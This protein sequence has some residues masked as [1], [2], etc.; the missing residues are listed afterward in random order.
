MSDV[1]IGRRAFV[2]GS[3]ALAGGSLLRLGWPAALAA[4]QAACSARDEGAAFTTLTPGEAREFEAVAARIL[5]TTA[6]PGAREAGVIYFFDNLPNTP[7]AGMLDGLRGT[8][9]PFQA[10]I[11]ARFPGAQRFSDLGEADQDVWLAE[12]EQTPFFGMARMVTLTGFFAMSR[13][14]GNRDNIGWDLIGFDGPGPQQS[15]FGYYDAVYQRENGD[16]D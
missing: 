15:P 6:T 16:G 5:P 11:A 13:Y 10:G 3:G 8:L 12:N 14:G 1:S 7:L 2:R 9:R 4:A